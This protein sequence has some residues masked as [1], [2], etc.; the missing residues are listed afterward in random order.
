MEEVEETRRKYMTA[1]DLIASF[2]GDANATP[3]QTHSV[4]VFAFPPLC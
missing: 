2:L 4:I 3:V 1:S